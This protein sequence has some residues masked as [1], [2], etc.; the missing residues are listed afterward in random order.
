MTT[1][2][3]GHD[4]LV[5]VAALTHPL[6]NNLLRHSRGVGVRGVDQ[7]ATEFDETVEEVSGT[8]TGKRPTKDCSTECDWVDL[9]LCL[10]NSSRR[11][12]CLNGA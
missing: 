2:F 6:T 1:D 11:G 7:V 10:T 4:Y 3:G 5:P 12:F 9:D 8:T